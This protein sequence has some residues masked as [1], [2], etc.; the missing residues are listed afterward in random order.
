MLTATKTSS[1]DTATNTNWQVDPAIKT[2][3]QI[4]TT[5]PKLID[6]WIQQMNAVTKTKVADEYC[7][8]TKAS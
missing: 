8:A 1:I 7:T 3:K 2:N 4:K 5:K 6:R